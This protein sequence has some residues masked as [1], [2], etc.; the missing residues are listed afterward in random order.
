MIDRCKVPRPSSTKKQIYLDKNIYTV[1]SDCDIV[2]ECN[3]VY[4][5]DA[6]LMFSKL[7]LLSLL[8]HR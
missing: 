3:K 7:A 5:S 8:N 1:C 4:C 6:S 2:V